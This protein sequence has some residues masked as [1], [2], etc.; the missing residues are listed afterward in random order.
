MHESPGPLITAL[1]QLRA[2]ANSAPRLG[3]GVGIGF[4]VPIAI[5]LRVHTAPQSR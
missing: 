3:V 2:A 4:E 1:V 5:G